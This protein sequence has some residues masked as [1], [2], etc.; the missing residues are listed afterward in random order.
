MTEQ[1]TVAGL[2]CGEVLAELSSFVDGELE[3]ERVAQIELHLRG[4]D[5]CERFGGEFTDLV[6]QLR[7]QLGAASELDRNVENRLHD[8]L[9]R[10]FN[11]AEG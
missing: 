6:Q 8:R 9:I 4:C 2:R 5:W 7:Q 1:R 3:P 10:E 11:T